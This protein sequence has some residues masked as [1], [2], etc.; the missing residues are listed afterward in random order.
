M[1]ARW[2]AVLSLLPALRKKAR[3]LGAGPA[4]LMVA[5]WRGKA[6]A[7]LGRVDE[8]LAEVEKLKGRADIAA[9]AY[10]TRLGIVHTAANDW[11]GA[12]R[13]YQS[14]LDAKP[15]DIFAWMG[16]SEVLATR[17]HRPQEARAAFE[18]LRGI[19]LSE[20]NRH[21]ID[22]VE[23]AVQ[24]AEGSFKEARAGLEAALTGFQRQARAMPVVE[25]AVAETQALLAI[26]CAKTGAHKSAREYFEAAEPFL[27]LHGDLELLE[28]CRRALGVR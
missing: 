9:E 16:L 26:V 7:R 12:A 1:K 27:T 6:L 24:V 25:A 23:A 8:A 28:R 20:S 13:C 19:P 2:E 15:D 21:L 22:A 18:A 5:E 14:A 3:G 17:L 4:D 11:E 10:W